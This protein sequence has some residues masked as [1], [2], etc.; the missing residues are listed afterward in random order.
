MR[1]KQS[2]RREKLNKS[3]ETV[4]EARE[5]VESVKRAKTRS[6]ES[7]S[8]SSPQDLKCQPSLVNNAM[9]QLGK[10]S[11]LLAAKGEGEGLGV[12]TFSP[13]RSKFNKLLMNSTT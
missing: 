3:R 13:F 5:K 8:R 2:K 11:G 9:L 1:E 7:G 12:T 10:N 6:G 4:G